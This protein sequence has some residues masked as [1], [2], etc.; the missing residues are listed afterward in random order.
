VGV[1]Y[2]KEEVTFYWQ[3]ILEWQEALWALDVK[4]YVMEF[5]HDAPAMTIQC[6]QHDYKSHLY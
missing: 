1:L 5:L 2:T 6:M 4:Y 3:P